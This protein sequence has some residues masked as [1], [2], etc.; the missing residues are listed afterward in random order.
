MISGGMSTASGIFG[1]IAN[2]RIAAKQRAQQYKMFREAN[3]FNANQA[4]IA[5]QRQI[6]EWNRQ[7]DLTNQYNDPSAQMNRLTSAGINPYNAAQSVSPSDASM[8][9]GSA[10]SPS[11]AAPPYDMPFSNPVSSFF[12]SAQQGLNTALQVLQT[13]ENSSSLA[14]RLSN[15]SSNA[16]LAKYNANFALNTL[17]L[18]IEATNQANKALKVED[19]NRETIAMLRAMN[20]PE[21]VATELTQIISSRQQSIL[22]VKYS[23]LSNEEKKTNLKYLDR[24]LDLTCK[25]LEADFGLKGLQ[26][27]QLRKALEYADRLYQADLQLKYAQAENQHESAV[28]MRETRWSRNNQMNM[29]AFNQQQQGYYTKK[30]NYWFAPDKMQR[31]YKGSLNG[32]PWYNRLVNNIGLGVIDAFDLFHLMK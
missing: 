19:T 14:D 27:K 6:D 8:S 29:N 11:S 7:F 24:Q 5:Y 17:P 26:A 9:V 1:S 2:S 15:I 23:E 21:Q 28:D 30:Q 18:S 4:T 10:S 12:D 25:N 22:A 31:A 3:Q 20:I 13:T 16:D 32:N